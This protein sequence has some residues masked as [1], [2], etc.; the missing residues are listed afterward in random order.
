VIDTR[1]GS[2]SG[3]ILLFGILGEV[4]YLKKFLWVGANGLIPSVI[5]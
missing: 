3:N 5:F 2:I 4:E 1:D